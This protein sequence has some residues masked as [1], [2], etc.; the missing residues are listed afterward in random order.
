MLVA[1]EPP[2]ASQ[3]PDREAAGATVR[4]IQHSYQQRGWGAGMAHFIAVVG[5]RGEF[6]EDFA[7]QPGPDPQTFGM[8]A[9]DNGDRTDVMLGQNLITCTHFEPDYDAL[10]SASTRI[11]LAAGEESHGEM[12][13]RGAYAVADRLGTTPV[14]FPSDHGGFLGGEYGQQPGKPAEFAAKLREVLGSN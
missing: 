14:V 6:D 10:R 13:N 1:H 4:A 2:L 8:P 11:V 5:H 3:L 9:E 7:K 12:A